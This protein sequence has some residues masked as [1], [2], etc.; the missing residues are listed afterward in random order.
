MVNFF[1]SELNKYNINNIDH[2]LLFYLAD[3]LSNNAIS[4]EKNIYLVDLYVAANKETC[5]NKRKDI[6]KYIA[7][8]SLFRCGFFEESTFNIKYY[9]DVGRSAYSEM[10]ILTKNNI[11][12]DL[13]FRYNDC[14]EL[15]SDYSMSTKNKEQQFAILLSKLNDENNEAIML[16]LKKLGL[17]KEGTHES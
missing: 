4:N 10:Y 9:I 15:L 5:K 2:L 12:N 7:D 14:R 17:Q 13:S 6:V 16:K 11:Y 3:V 1:L 8:Y